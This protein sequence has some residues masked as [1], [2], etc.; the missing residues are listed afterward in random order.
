MIVLNFKNNQQADAVAGVIDFSINLIDLK[1]AK[2]INS[3]LYDLCISIKET[4]IYQKDDNVLF[5]KG[6]EVEFVFENAIWILEQ[7][8]KTKPN[9]VY[10]NSVGLMKD[11]LS[12]MKQKKT[13]NFI[14]K[15]FRK[16]DPDLLEFYNKNIGN[17]FLITKDFEF[18]NNLN[19]PLEKL[20]K[21]PKKG[22]IYI[23]TKYIPFLGISEMGPI[24]DSIILVEKLSNIPFDVSPS[25]F[26]KISILK[27]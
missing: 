7:E 2:K 13:E 18:E 23:L 26:N 12:V 19:I 6:P 24:E 20:P 22:E 11:I 10:F 9:D 4:L 1:D 8:I 21:M 16:F 5:L 14:I 15:D 17:E 25:A 3:S 27:K